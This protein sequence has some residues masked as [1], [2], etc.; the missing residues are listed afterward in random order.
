M[1]FDSAKL[2]VAP[3]EHDPLSRHRADSKLGF[4][5]KDDAV[6]ELAAT[7]PELRELHDRLNAQRTWALLIILQAMDAAGKDGIVKHVLTGFNQQS[8][9]VTSFSAPAGDEVAHSF[10]WRT[11]T[12]LP[13]RGHIGVF[14][15][16]YYEEVLVPRVHPEYLAYQRLPPECVRHDVT[17]PAAG[18]KSSSKSNSRALSTRKLSPTALSHPPPAFWQHRLDDMNAFERHLVRNGTRVVK[19]FLHI[20]RDEQKRRFLAR[21]DDPSRNWKF[22]PSDVR[23]RGFW[24]Q[25]HHAYSE[26][27]TQTSTPWAPW[28]VIP[29]DHKYVARLAVAKILRQELRELNPQYPKLDTAGRQALHKAEKALRKEHRECNPKE[30]EF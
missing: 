6:N 18:R 5:D 20:S 12:P 17:D 22:S 10:L 2:R 28:Y 11:T 21:I 3:G 1:P 15:R 8:C 9:H 25:Y 26:V 16:S 19:F 24:A 23:D 30:R 4:G 29:A 27:L 7:L 13:P 14:N